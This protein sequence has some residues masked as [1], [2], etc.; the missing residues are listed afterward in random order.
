[1]RAILAKI[2]LDNG[3]ILGRP[4]HRMKMW[5]LSVFKST[6]YSVQSAITKVMTIQNNHLVYYTMTQC[7]FY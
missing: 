3:Y 1:L 4:H 7:K 5:L 6:N 2:M